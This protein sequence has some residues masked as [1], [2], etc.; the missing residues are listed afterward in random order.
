VCGRIREARVSVEAPPR[1]QAE[2]D[3]ARTPLESSLD[4][5]GVVTRVEDEQ[6]D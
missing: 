5:D 6:G 2:E 3:L 4:L 1:A